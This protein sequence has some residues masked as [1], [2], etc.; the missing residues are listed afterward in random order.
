MGARRPVWAWEACYGILPKVS[1]TFALSIAQLKEPL[2]GSVCVSYLL[3]RIL[4]TVEDAPG[5]T[6][7]ERWSLMEPVVF[8]LKD[9][10]PCPAGW[11]DAAA[12]RLEG[13]ASSS[14]RELLGSAPAVLEA[15][16]SCGEEDRL[17]MARW[18]TEMGK[19]MVAWSERMGEGPGALKRLPSM[20][21]LDRYCY[22]I[23]GTVGYLLTDLY[24]IHSPH[25]DRA[26]FFR[27]QADAEEFGLGLQ[28][29]NIVKD[30]AEDYERGWC[31]IPQDALAAA[32]VTEADFSR[33]DRHEA[34]YRGVLPVLRTAAAHLARAWTYLSIFPLEEKEIRFFLATSLF[35]A[36]ETLALVAE[37]PSRLTAPDKLK[38]SRA[39]VAALAAELRLKISRPEALAAL[40]EERSSPLRVFGT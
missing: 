11:G 33:P 36:L 9:I 12:R 8:H 18:V 30:L 17:A 6:A 38:I 4:D 37:K 5:L 22:Y 23:A 39:K 21:A 26:L 19:G 2:K 24:Y 40:Y 29:V 7:A 1:R 31:F 27:L 10:R 14:D 20:A 32:G 28:K 3:C 13:L 25:V 15:F 34:V 16:G 35:F